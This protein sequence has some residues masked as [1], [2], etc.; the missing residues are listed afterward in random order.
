MGIPLHLVISTEQS[1]EKIL[2]GAE[3]RTSPEGVSIMDD[4][5]KSPNDMGAF[6]DLS[7]AT[8]ISR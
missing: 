3:F 6:G 2:L 8:P 4:T 5:N 1:D 7:I